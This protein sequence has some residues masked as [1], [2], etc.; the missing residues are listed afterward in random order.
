AQLEQQE[1]KAKLKQAAPQVKAK[2]VT[3]KLTY[4]ERKEKETIDEEIEV[5]EQKINDCDEQMIEAS[6]DYQQLQVLMETKTELE[7]ELEVKYERW[8]YLAEKE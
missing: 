5:L 3:N 4:H 1:Q 7:A 8:E 2:A 6:S